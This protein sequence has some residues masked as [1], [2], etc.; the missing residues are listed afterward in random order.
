M[1][2]I[3]HLRKQPFLFAILIWLAASRSIASDENI[4]G[5]DLAAQIKQ[6]DAH[7]FSADGEQRQQLASMLARDVRMRRD[8]ANRRE[9]AAWQKI[10]TRPEWEQFRAVRI[11]ALRESLGQFPQASQDPRVRVTQSLEGKGYRIENLVFESR[12]GL[13]VTANRYLPANAERNGE[14]ETATK[15]LPLLPSILICHSHHNPKTQGELQDM[16]IT[17]ARLG[18]VV[19][20]MDQLGHGERQQHPFHTAA[21]YPGQFR[22]GRQDYYFRYNLGMQLHVMGDSLM[23]WMAWDLMRGVDVLLATKNSS[24]PANPIH[25]DPARIILL[26]AVAGG[27]DPAAVTAALDSRIAAVVPFN[28]GG[29]QPETKYPLSE[30]AETSFNYAG[31]GS[32]ESTRNLRLS[33][34]DGFLPWVIVGSVAPRRLVYGH[35]FAWDRPRDPV[36]RR[37]ERI[38]HLYEVPD[39]LAAAHGHGLLS[40]QPPDS[41]HCNNVGPEHR[42]GIY[43]AFE[44]WFGIAAPAKESS[45]RR[46]AKE[47]TCLTAEVAAELKPRPVCE[48]AAELGMQRTAAARRRLGGLAP[49]EQRRQLR[50]DWARLLGDVEPRGDPKI[51]QSGMETLADVIVERI[52]LEVEPGIIVPLV[53]FIPPNTGRN[54]LPVVVALS[55]EGKSGFLKHRSAQVAELLAGRATL[56][57]PDLRGTGETRPD[58]ESRGRS[59]ASTSISSSEFMLGQTLVGSRLRDLRSVL[60]YLRT[61][62]ELDASRI[63]LWGDSFAPSNPDDRRLEVP[64]DADNFPGLAEPLGGLMALLGALFEDPIHAVYVRGGLIGFQSLL[65]SPYCYVPHD[66]IVP[67]AL[68]AGDLCD[69]AAAL[70]PRPLRLDDLVDGLNR[71]ARQAVLDQTFEITRNAYRAAD[72]SDRLRFSN[73]TVSNDSPA[74][75]ILRH[76]G[77]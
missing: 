45:E 2:R 8:A 52:A 30:D 55:E 39:H 29:P 70:A 26:G 68:A 5:S 6:F 50:H 63:A 14:H 3:C 19:L 74:K 38:Y 34:R 7:V 20:V 24:N 9:S 56:C 17:W 13:V 23:G 64:L 44:R 41:S 47:L 22:V 67:G 28:F 75:W 65:D 25:V 35:E 57:L 51:I 76:F 48:L 31:G 43:A 33:A 16:G 37:L 59:G 18:C 53:L 46:T 1:N 11:Q 10:E 49:A 77:S 40:G 15:L 36:W 66:S 61:R 27:G 32:W 12:P 69:V 58:G 4:A 62:P 21:D 60:R 73:A 71:N 42:R 72:T 54:R